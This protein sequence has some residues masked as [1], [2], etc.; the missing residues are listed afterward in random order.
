MRWSRGCQS[1]AAVIDTSPWPLSFGKWPKVAERLQGLSV[2]RAR[3]IVL[4]TELRRCHDEEYVSRF[5]EGAM[6][7]GEMRRVGIAWSAALRERVLRVTGATVQAARMVLE[8][9]HRGVAVVGGGAHHAHFD[10]GAGYCVWNDVAAAALVLSETVDKVAVVD[11]DVHQGDGTIAILN[12][13]PELEGKVY[14]LDVCA[15]KN[16]PTR[17]QT[18]VPSR[19]N[20]VLLKDGLE[21]DDYLAELET[22][23]SVL[24]RDFGVPKVV[25]FQ[26]GVDPLKSDRLGRLGL[27]MQGMKRRDEGVYAFCKKHNASIIS[28]CGGGYYEPNDPISFETVVA[29]HVQQIRGLAEWFS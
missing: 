21:D 23:L 13:M 14:I 26:A 24:E 16:F 1:G 9:S 5:L 8:G 7:E 29:A 4:P 11:L 28:M 3:R 2:H 10:F 15:G 20:V 18:L 12:R 25:L 22:G 6:S 19:G 17:K 27:S